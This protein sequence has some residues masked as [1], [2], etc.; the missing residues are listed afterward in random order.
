MTEAL[1]ASE[2]EAKITR[3]ILNVAKIEPDRD[4]FDDLLERVSL[5]R[6]LRVGVWIRRFAHNSR[7]KENKF[8]PITAE[9][10]ERERSWWIK[11]IQER[12]RLEGHYTKIKAELNLQASEDN[13]A[14]CHGRIQGKHPIYLPRSA[15]FT[16]KL[17]ERMHYE[18]LHGEWG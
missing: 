14:V 12:D 17:V 3:E 13:V 16:E 6:T 9:E 2:K 1:P 10:V 4:E 7:N 8:G 11:R 5:R 18:T 15:V